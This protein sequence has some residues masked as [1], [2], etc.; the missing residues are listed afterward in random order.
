MEKYKLGSIYINEKIDTSL[1][2]MKYLFN[3]IPA[4]GGH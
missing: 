3:C 1:A 4:H 2:D